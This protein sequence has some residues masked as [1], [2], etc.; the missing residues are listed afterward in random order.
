MGCWTNVHIND[1]GKIG[2]YLIGDGELDNLSEKYVDSWGMFRNTIEPIAKK[3]NLKS[4]E[5]D[6][7]N[8]LFPKDIL[9]K[10][11]ENIKFY[12][13]EKPD[14]IDGV[15][16]YMNNHDLDYIWLGIDY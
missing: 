8:Y 4:D 3:Y 11:K 15:I 13:E 9:L 6:N 7:L 10:E 16:T 14:W 2:R 12:W 1:N 5:Y